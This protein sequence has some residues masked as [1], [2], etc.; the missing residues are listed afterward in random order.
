VEKSLLSVIIE[1]CDYR[2]IIAIICGVVMDHGRV[3]SHYV[4]QSTWR[5]HDI[6]IYRRSCAPL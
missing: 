6:A 1:Y 5:Y 4:S 3:T 2:E